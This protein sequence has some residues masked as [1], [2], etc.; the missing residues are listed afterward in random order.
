MIESG[1]E[2]V[3]DLGCGEGKLIRHLMKQKQFSE[4]VGI[5]VSYSELLKAKERLKFEE[6]APKQK[7]RVKLIQGSLTYKDNRLEGYDA[8]AVVEVIEHLDLNR[9][10][11]FEKVIFQCAKP[12]TVILTTPNKE[13]NVVWETLDS[14]EMRHDDHRFE[15]TRKEF[16]DWSSRIGLE[17][18]YRVE[19]LPVG[20]EV[21]SVGAPSQMAIFTYGN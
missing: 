4:I 21:E 7:E 5:D 18:N 1:A 3:L 13:Y 15:W 19:L 10:D 20:D 6:M 11:A 16:E 17:Y 2:R 12:K 8:A 14:E 9:L